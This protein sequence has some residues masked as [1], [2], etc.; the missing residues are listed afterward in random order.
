MIVSSSMSVS[1]R[2]YFSTNHLRAATFFAK[3]SYELEAGYT[4]GHPVADCVRS[5]HRSCVVSAV[6]M[7]A[8]FMEA[9]INELFSDVA[10]GVSR[11]RYENMPG[12]ER[13]AESWRAGIPRRAGYSILEKFDVALLLSDKH[14]FSKGDHAYQNAADVIRLQNALVHY[15][16]ESI[17]GEEKENRKVHDFEKK[18][19]RR[20]TPCIFFE[21]SGNPFYP[22]HVLGAGCAVWAVKSSVSLVEN[23]FNQLGI[24]VPYGSFRDSLGISELNKY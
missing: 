24:Q 7:S 5:E 23:F 14:R 10:D 11:A 20:F 2:H 4:S 22:D 18:L 3:R 19:T 17:E 12:C 21:G 8:A 6:V 1:M 15:E 16:P 13:L 9:T